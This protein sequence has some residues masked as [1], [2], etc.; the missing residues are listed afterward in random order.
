MKKLVALLLAVCLVFGLMTTVFAAEEKADNIV[1]LY[2]NDVHC[3]VDDNLGYAGLAAY[4]AEMEAANEHVVLVDCG[5]AA[6]G[7]PIGTLSKGEYLIDIMNAVG[8]DYATFGNHEFDYGMEALQNLIDKAQFQYLSSNL[9]YTGAEGKG[10]TGYKA[11][12]VATYGDVKVAFVGIATPESFT[13]STPTYFQN[14]KGDYVY[15]FCEGNDGADLY[16]NVQATVDA[17]KADGADYVVAIAH[18]GIDE[19]S[20]PWRSTDLIANTTGIDVVLDGHSHSTVASEE[21]ANKAGENV[22]LSSTGTKLNAIGKLVITADGTITTELVTDYA[23]KDETADAFVKDIQAQNQVLLD[24]VV[25]KS[26]VD[27]TTK[28]ADGT[29]AVRN[30]ETNLGD[31]CADAYRIVSG[32]DIAFVNGGGIRADLSAGD[33][34]YGDVITVHPYG[35]ALCVVEATGQ[36]IIDA[37]EWAARNTAG[38]ASDGTNSIGEMGGFLQVSGLK[39]T[40]DTGVA[41]SAKGDDKSMFAAVEG[42]YRVKNVQVLTN[43][44]YVPIDPKATYELASHNYML[45]SGGDGINMFMDNKLLQDE[46]MLDNQV[47]ITYIE[48]YLNGV[49]P[50]TYAK[51]QGRITFIPTKYADV[52]D[53]NWAVAAINYV[54]E[55]GIMNGTGK[56]FDPNGS[57]TRGQLVTMLYR[58]AGKPE[59]EGKLSDTFTDCEDGKWYSNAVLWA[60]QNKIVNGYGDVFKPNQA[61]TRQEMA[62]ILYGYDVA[63]NGAEKVEAAALS[64]KDADTVASWALEGVAYCTAKKILSGSNGNFSPANTA[65]R[66]MGAQVFMNIGKLAAAAEEAT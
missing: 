23:A 45:K 15:S 21:V 29:R 44:K 32:A 4:K 11:Y 49:V 22:L 37:L 20:E 36:E 54:T 1:V 9:V 53:G 6:Q 56:N 66:A 46:V 18:L 35:N 34:T 48:D 10:L 13:K 62:K 57:L 33:I 42:E 58:Q 65:T 16:A 63:V 24:T 31:L 30:R 43:G 39:Y 50:A 2:T 51:P 55:A 5:D 26:T 40:I 12:D 52:A 59:V 60:A 17:A 7:G 19:S 27:L 3:A 14:E 28:N 25:A 61:V 38:L 41:S 64:Y 47:L 8:Y